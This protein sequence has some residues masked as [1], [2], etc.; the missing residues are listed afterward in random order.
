VLGLG[1]SWVLGA[2]LLHVDVE[3]GGYRQ[4]VRRHGQTVEESEEACVD[5]GLEGFERLLVG[6]LLGLQLRL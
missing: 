3:R 2:I 6:Q 4:A 5:G 1:R